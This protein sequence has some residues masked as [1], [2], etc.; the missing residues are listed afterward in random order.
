MISD[1]LGK[2]VRICNY[3]G[4]KLLLDDRSFVDKAMLRD[5]YWEKAEIDYFS[6]LWQYGS[7]KKKFFFDIG[8]YFGLY[9]LHAWMSKQFDEIHAFEADAYNYSQL[10]AQMFLNEAM[11]IKAHNLAVS[12]YSGISRITSSLDNRDNRGVT[13][14]SEEGR[15]EV[16]C[17]ALDAMFPNLADATV[18]VKIDVEGHELR[19]LK[20]MS[21]IIKNN[22]AVLQIEIYREENKYDFLDEYGLRVINEVYPDVFVT[23]IADIALGA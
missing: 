22:Q 7:G 18:F 3:C 10:R 9:S 21:D 6:V 11:G 17:T 12:D 1:Y 20:G 2:D 19:V 5:G 14:L 15:E 4:L 13:F 8:S 23:N 16:E